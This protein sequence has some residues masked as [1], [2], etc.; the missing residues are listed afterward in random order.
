MVLISH[1]KTHLLF[2]EYEILKA[3]KKWGR[4]GLFKGLQ[5]LILEF[6]SFFSPNLGL[7]FVTKCFCEQ[8]LILTIVLANNFRSSSRGSSRGLDRMLYKQSNT[9]MFSP[10]IQDIK[11]HEYVCWLSE[12]VDEWKF[13]GSFTHQAFWCP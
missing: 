6:F 1:R 3:N 7:K 4:K 13:Q 2:S 12:W 5:E 9:T 8:K 11:L 10:E